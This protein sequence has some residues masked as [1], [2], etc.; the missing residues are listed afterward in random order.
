[1]LD[2]LRQPLETG[3]TVIARANHRIAYPSRFQLIA[4]MN[5]CKCGGGTPGQ[6]C[7]RGQRCAAE[8]QS[9][10][11]GP[12][13]DRIDLRIEVPQVSAADLVLPAP[14]EGS[15]E[16]RALERRRLGKVGGIREGG[17]VAI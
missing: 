17:A 16:V 10:L 11:S 12:F 15:A 7:R 8:Y 13:L 6:A 1:M 9:R 3:E 5:P 4:A 2:S 14:T